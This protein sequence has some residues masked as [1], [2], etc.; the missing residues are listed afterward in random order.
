MWHGVISPSTTVEG[1]TLYKLYVKSK[2]PSIA[3]LVQHYHEQPIAVS[4]QG[5]P[6]VLVG[7]DED[8][9]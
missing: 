8:D 2:F 6:V 5:Q 9:E 1:K 7:D 3:D 4:P